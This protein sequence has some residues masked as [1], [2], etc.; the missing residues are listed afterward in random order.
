MYACKIIIYFASVVATEE[1][2]W[3][4][5]VSF[6]IIRIPV[7]FA[8]LWCSWSRAAPK[9]SWSRAAACKVVIAAKHMLILADKVLRK[10]RWL[11]KLR[12][13]KPKPKETIIET[14]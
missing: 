6:I 9:S 14:D 11:K 4:A 8:I 5:F 10:K 1:V 3:S 2:P 12:I 7:F 13:V